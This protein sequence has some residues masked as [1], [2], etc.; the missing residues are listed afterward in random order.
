MLNAV[1]RNGFDYFLLCEDSVTMP[2]VDTGI[3]DRTFPWGFPEFLRI[4]LG[5]SPID[6]PPFPSQLVGAEVLS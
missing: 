2:G 3:I 5:L 1:A 6:S 4:S